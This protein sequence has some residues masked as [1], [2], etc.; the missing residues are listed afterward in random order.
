MLNL[1]WIE[2]ATKIGLM[3]LDIW[4]RKKVVFPVLILVSALA[5]VIHYEI[6]NL[7]TLHL[8]LF[9]TITTLLLA[10]IGLIVIENIENSGDL[11]RVPSLVTETLIA[12]TIVLAILLYLS[13]MLFGIFPAPPLPMLLALMF[14]MAVAPLVTILILIPPLIGYIPRLRPKWIAVRQRVPFW[15]IYLGFIAGFLVMLP[16]LLFIDLAF[17]GNMYIMAIY[18]GI[19]IY[20]SF[21]LLVSPRPLVTKSLGLL[22]VAMGPISWFGAAGGLALGSVL[23]VI[24]GAYA[25]SWSPYGHEDEETK[26]RSLILTKT[27][28]VKEFVG[29]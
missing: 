13:G 25:F 3:F 12:V 2:K 4:N 17:L 10:F 24:A 1:N 29:R 6:P 11:T 22:M 20:C 26:L 27:Q 28:K 8:A 18:G 5:W 14:A 15:G 21:M 23:A 9:P 19:L 7:I 16:L